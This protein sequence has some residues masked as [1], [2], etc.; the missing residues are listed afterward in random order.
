MAKLRNKRILAIVARKTQKEHPRNGQSQRTSVPRIDQEH[1]T[2]LSEEIEGK[3][4][5]KLLQEFKTESPI[6]GALSK[7]E[8]VVLN[9]QIRMHSGTV[10]GT[11]RNTNVGSR[12]PNE[13]RSQDDSHPEMRP[14]VCQSLHSSDL[15]PDEAP[16][17]VTG[18]QEMNCYRPHSVTTFRDEIP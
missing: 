1:I 15:D 11:F 18:V 14:P 10:P 12:E 17:V 8:E 7:I 6:L 2:Q 13:D 4:I 3:V 9:P 5:R 16:H